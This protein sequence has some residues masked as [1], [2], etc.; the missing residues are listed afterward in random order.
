[1]KREKFVLQSAFLLNDE[2]KFPQQLEKGLFKRVCGCKKL[3]VKFY[4]K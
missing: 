2:W 4:K 3:S 1:M